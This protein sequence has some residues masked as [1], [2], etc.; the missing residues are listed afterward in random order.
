MRME[1]VHDQVCP[2]CGDSHLNVY[3]S[4]YTDGKLGKWCE[5]CNLKAY[6]CSETSVLIS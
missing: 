2:Q 6:Y 5:S 4:D 3:F 1:S